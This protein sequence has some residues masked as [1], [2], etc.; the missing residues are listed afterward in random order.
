MESLFG[1]VMCSHLPSSKE[2]KARQILAPNLEIQTSSDPE[3]EDVDTYDPLQ[4]SWFRQLPTDQILRHKK[5][6]GVYFCGAWSSACSGVT[7]NLCSI[8]ESVRSVHAAQ[9]SGHSPFEII[10]AS[11]DRD[12]TSF[13]AQYDSMPWL[14]IPYQN[15]KVVQD[16]AQQF[17]VSS[18]PSVVLLDSDGVIIA[19]N[20]IHV[21]REFPT[22]FPWANIDQ[23]RPVSHIVG[24]TFLCIKRSKATEATH[25]HVSFNARLKGNVVLLFFSAFWSEEGREFTA[26][27]A[28]LYKK[29]KSQKKRF[30]VV[31]VSMGHDKDDFSNY[32]QEM[33]SWLA[34][35]FDDGKRRH[36]LQASF[37]INISTLPQVVVLDEDEQMSLITKRGVHHIRNDTWGLKFP[38]KRPH[39]LDVAKNMGHHELN[40]FPCMVLLAEAEDLVGGKDEHRELSRVLDHVAKEHVTRCNNTGKLQDILY[41]LAK[42]SSPVSIQIRQICGLP[43]GSDK[44]SCVILNLSENGAAYV[45]RSPQFTEKSATHFVESWRE[46]K[47]NTRQQVR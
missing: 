18:V 9:N 37:D 16:L 23:R 12:L 5:V 26:V 17:R 24:D 19:R 28:K 10:F 27:L 6:I 25:P 29:L 42:T 45:L 2:N 33:P 43:V 4:K 38:W 20:G 14:A 15:R 13:N 47:L 11:V 44:W 35:P 46:G 30:E 8:Y 7:S 22:G 3:E 36:A 41:F 32:L 31:F 40:T 39:V 21:L 1:S 34:V